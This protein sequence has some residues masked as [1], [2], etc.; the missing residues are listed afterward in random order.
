VPENAVATNNSPFAIVLYQG[1][2]AI[3]GNG[4]LIPIQ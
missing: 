2:N 3:Y 4:S 1:T